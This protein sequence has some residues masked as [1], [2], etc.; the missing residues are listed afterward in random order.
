M[1]SR[2]YNTKRNIVASYILMIVQILF[3]FIS[4]TVIV[5]TLGAEFLGLS[6]LFT[7]ILQVLNIAESGFSSSIIYFMYKPLADGDTEKVNALLNYLRKIYKLVG[8]VILIVGLILTPFI[9]QLIKGDVPNDINVYI[10]YLLYLFNTCISYFLFAYKI[11][12]LTAIQ[13]LDITK[14]ANLIVILLQYTLQLVALILFYN[15]YLFVIAM[16]LGTGA[17]NLFTAYISMKKYPEYNCKGNIDNK[18]KKDILKKVKGLLICNISGVTYNAFDSI[19]ISA[20]IGLNSVAIYNNYFIIFSTVSSFVAIIRSSMQA[21]VGNSVASESVEKNYSD[22]QL[23]QFLF[24]LIATWC[25]ACLICLY[26]PF[27]T[28]W[29]GDNMLLPFIDVILLGCWFLEGTVQHAFYL[30]LSATGLWN[31]MKLPYICSTIFN[32]VMNIILGKFMGISGIVLSS[33]LAGIIFGL[34]WQCNIIFKSYFN[35]SSISYILNQFI[36]FII[37]A[38]VII[39]SYISCSFVVIGGIRELLFKAVICIVITTGLL[40]ALYHRNTHFTRSKYLIL[41]VIQRH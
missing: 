21:S 11:S 34:L 39:V 14:Y 28:I 24:S 9:E 31:E 41:K 23:W 2:T 26:Q 22:L 15:Y 17:T 18:C 16:I 38:V 12:F 4:R 27:M 33:L 5:Y 8:G 29:M 1:N 6:S 25:A 19:I 10:L 36:Y 40:Y 3:S 32:L 13:R 35:K 37:A 7:S 30:Y 20:Y